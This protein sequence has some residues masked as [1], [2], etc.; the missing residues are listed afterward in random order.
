MTE[1]QEII[2]IKNFFSILYVENTGAAFSIL[3]DS[4]LLLIIIS[5]LFVIL[6]GSYIKKESEKFKKAEVVS[7]GL[8]LGGIFG[9]MI[10]RIIHRKVTDYLSF[11]I[12]KYEFPIFNFA[13]MCIV[14]GAIILLIYILF[15]DKT[16]NRRK[17]G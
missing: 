1:Y 13:D 10:D 3:K 14:V 8:I 16:S 5:V 17:N 4:T 11:N 6:L 9:N 12:I 7:Y 2:I 15:I